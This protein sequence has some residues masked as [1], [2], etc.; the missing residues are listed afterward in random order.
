[1]QR[2]IFEDHYEIFLGLFHIE[3]LEWISKLA[4]H[5]N[6][7]KGDE[8]KKW[9]PDLIQWLKRI[10]NYV[11]RVV[12]FWIDSMLGGFNTE[13]VIDQIVSYSEAK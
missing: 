12:D 2:Y 3:L 1:L 13:F 11:P 4:E 10:D 6:S 7:F 9:N 5:K 8:P